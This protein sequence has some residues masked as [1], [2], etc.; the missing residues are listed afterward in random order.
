MTILEGKSFSDAKERLRNVCYVSFEMRGPFLLTF[1]GVSTD[2]H[3]QLVSQLSTPYNNGTNFIVFSRGVFVP[4]QII[5]FAIVPHHLRFLVVSVVSLFWSESY[6]SFILLFGHA[7]PFLS[8]AF[9]VF[10]VLSKC[11]F[12]RYVSQCSQ[13]QT[14]SY[15]D[16]RGDQIRIIS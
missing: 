12:R 15:A 1:L 6:F 16:L 4:T 7:I 11:C 13:C 2:T 9:L 10:P 8:I 14:A 3:A 5:N